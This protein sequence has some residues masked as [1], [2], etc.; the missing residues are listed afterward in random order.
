MFTDRLVFALENARRSGETIHLFLIDVDRF[1]R[2]NTEFGHEIGDLMLRSLA[3]RILS[4]LPASS[5]AF[6]IGGDEFML[7]EV[8]PSVPDIEETADL[9]LGELSAPVILAGRETRITID[10]G[11]ISSNGYDNVSSIMQRIELALE[12][13]KQS[14][15]QRFSIAWNEHA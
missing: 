11:V 9:L 14:P 3:K 1:R 12:S 7:L 4:V 13:A 8:G 10:I 15:D 2:F 5:T 6:R